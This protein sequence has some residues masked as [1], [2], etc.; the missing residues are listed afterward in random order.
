MENPNLTNTLFR[1]GVGEQRV[2]VRGNL[3]LRDPRT[4]T[5]W[6][7][8][9]AQEVSRNAGVHLLRFRSILDVQSVLILCAPDMRGVGYVLS[10]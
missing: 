10:G 7:F 6:S 1:F 3:D 8:V 5:K 2:L 4:V 9:N